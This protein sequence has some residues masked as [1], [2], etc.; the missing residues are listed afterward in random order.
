M[1]VARL[2]VVFALIACCGWSAEAQVKGTGT[3]NYVP[4]WE[5]STTLENSKIFQT[6]GNVGI[7]TTS[8]AAPL[9]VAGQINTSSGYLIGDS[10]FLAE[11]GGS[12]YLNT[13]VGTEA[14]AENSG[15]S[16]NSAL[17]WGALFGNTTGENNTAVGYGAMAQN[18]SGKNN[19][20]YGEEAL[21]SN[22]TGTNNIAMGYMAAFGVAGANSNN[23]HIGS[24]GASADSGTVR[25]GTSGKQTSFFV[26]GVSGVTTGDNDALPV[27]VD[28]NGQL[29]TVNSSRRFKEDIQDMGDATEDLMRLRPVT[30]RYQ[31]P[32]ADG[33]KPVQ[34]GL[35][36]EEVAEVYPEMVAHSADGQ[37][38][39]VKYQMLDSMLLNEV[40]RQQAEI[41][42]LQQK[43]EKMEAL[44]ASLSN[45]PENAI[46]AA[47]PNPK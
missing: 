1:R 37:I 7:G 29:G 12:A 45:K 32:F 3:T 13:A 25:I 43:L 26:A 15:G 19:E 30:F 38:Q 6:G 8:P 41:Q 16:A 24:E 27:L 14:L 34:F 11:P 9:D 36:A 21:Y 42:T 23:I 10:L 39:A 22:S 5:N 28:T 47:A 46:V 31:K 2:P 18:T 44:L 33:S 20:A 17:G 40:Q 4:L 35:I